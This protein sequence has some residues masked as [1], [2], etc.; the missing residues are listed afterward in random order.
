[1][2]S[3]QRPI[4][5]PTPVLRSPKKD[6]RTWQQ[7]VGK[8]LEARRQGQVLREGKPKSFRQIVGRA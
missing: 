3:V 5:E 2:T 7:R 1:M 6:D 4:P 8:A